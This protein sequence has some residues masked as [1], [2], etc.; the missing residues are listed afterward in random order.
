MDP[1]PETTRFGTPRSC[2]NALTFLKNVAER[3]EWGGS[4][5]KAYK[6]YKKGEIDR[7]LLLYSE[8]AEMGYDVAQVSLGRKV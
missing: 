4:L 5:Q 8:L 7:S 3:G 2:T 6:L 1:R